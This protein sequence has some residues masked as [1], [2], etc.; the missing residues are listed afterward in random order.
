[1]TTALRQKG[2]DVTLLIDPQGRELRVAFEDFFIDKG[3]DPEARL[4]VWYA[5]HGHL[6]R[7]PE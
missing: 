4:F 2:F 6:L 5:G 1:M 3:D 7:S